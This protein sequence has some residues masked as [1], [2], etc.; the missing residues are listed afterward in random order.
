MPMIVIVDNMR[1][2][3]QYKRARISDIVVHV[4]AAIFSGSIDEG[5]MMTRLYP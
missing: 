5:V 3:T 4:L 1:R 2:L